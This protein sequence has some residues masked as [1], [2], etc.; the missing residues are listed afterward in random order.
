ML[1]GASVGSGDF[2]AG[3]QSAAGPWT[4]SRR[5]NSGTFGNSWAVDNSGCHVDI[6]KRGTVYSCKP[7]LALLNSSAAERARFKAFV[8]SIPDSHLA[9]VEVWHEMDVKLRKGGAPFT[10]MTLAQINAAKLTCY[11]I[12][13]QVAKPH[14]YTALILSGYSVSGGVSTGLPEQ[15]WVGPDGSTRL[16]DLVCW[17]TYMFNN[18]IT[19][20][21]HEQG[22][23]IAFA[24]AHGADYGLTELGIHNAVTDYTAAATWLQN[25]VDYAFTHGGTGDHQSGS[26]ISFFDRAQDVAQPVPSVN[27]TMMALSAS[28]SAQYLTPYTTFVL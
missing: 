13:K 5:Y 23:G 26:I 16:I 28:V 18:T 15:F 10:S 4:V 7:D 21:S 11:D 25:Q 1:I 8:Q 27:S 14:V 19:T 12:I 24:A 3:E 20:G 17:D 9:F 6:G 2:N 22:G